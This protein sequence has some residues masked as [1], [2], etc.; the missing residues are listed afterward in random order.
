MFT[1]IL[2]ILEEFMIYDLNFPSS[3]TLTQFASA[4][5]YLD[6]KQL[7]GNLSAF[8]YLLLRLKICAIEYDFN[9]TDRMSVCLAFV[10]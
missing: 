7:I 9:S 5:D 3:L 1:P 10:N 4:G 2:K 6:N 8:T